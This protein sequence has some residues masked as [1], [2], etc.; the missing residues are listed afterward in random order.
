MANKEAK[1]VAKAM[2]DNFILIYGVIKEI[3]TDQGSEY[4][5][6]LWK[7]ITK[8]LKID[9]KT[10]TPYHSQTIGGCERNHRVLNEYVRM[11]INEAHMDWDEWIKY[12]SFCYNTTPSSY[13]NYTPFELVYGKSL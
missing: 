4:K 9:H 7:N 6:E 12:Y 10:S 3:R 2:L 5:N 8:L 11:Y 13:H 1:T